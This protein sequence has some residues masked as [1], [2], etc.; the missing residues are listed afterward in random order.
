LPCHSELDSIRT[1][2][3]PGVSVKNVFKDVT[4]KCL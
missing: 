2:W 4:Y 3:L 1:R